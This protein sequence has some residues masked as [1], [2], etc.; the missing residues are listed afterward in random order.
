MALRKVMLSADH[1]D[2]ILESH[3]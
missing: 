1:E 2:A 3:V